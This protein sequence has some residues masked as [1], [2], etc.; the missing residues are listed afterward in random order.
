[1]TTPKQYSVIDDVV[2]QTDKV[3]KGSKAFR[4]GYTFYENLGAETGQQYQILNTVDTNDK[5]NSQGYEKNGFQGMAVAPIVN[6]EPDYNHVIIAFAGTNATDW[7]LND[8]SADLSNVVL[9]FEKDGTLESQFSSAQQFYKEMA[10]KY[11]AS[12]IE[13]V[14][15]HSLGGA[16]AQKVAATNHIPAVTFSTAGVG[17]QLTEEEKAWINGKGKKFVLNFMHKGDQ[18]SSWTHASNYGTAIYVGDFGDGTLLSGHFLESYH[19][20]EDGSLKDNEGR[21]WTITDKGILSDGIELIQKSFKSQMKAL[22][23]LKVR[24]TASGGG[25]SSGEKIYLDAAE[26]LAIISTAGAEFNLAMLNVIKNYQEGIKKAEE[27]W[28]K[29]RDEAIQMGTQLEK[30]EVHEA[31]ESVGFTE[32]NIVAVPRQQYQMKIDKIREMSEHFTSLE[33]EI[34]AKISEIVA[35]DAELAQEL[36]G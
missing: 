28:K 17:K 34:K 26:A 20:G 1:M 30:W 9:G 22:E 3:K 5:H 36:K 33:R 8:L 19:F 29:T 24:F 13:A 7:H 27:L 15:G 31:L 6:G 11:G 21:I 16:L 35:R 12:N 23:D 14:T 2:Y 32:Y 25:L 4:K 10:K 18:V